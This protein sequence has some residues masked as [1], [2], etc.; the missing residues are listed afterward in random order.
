MHSVEWTSTY[1]E[2]TIAMAHR[3]CPVYRGKRHVKVCGLAE[4]RRRCFE[5]IG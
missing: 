3:G 1:Q 4:R 2:L 5:L